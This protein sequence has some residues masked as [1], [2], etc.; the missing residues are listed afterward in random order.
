MERNT[1]ISPR[2]IFAG[3]AEDAVV[4]VNLSDENENSADGR[5]QSDVDGL[6]DECKNQSMRRRRP[7][8]PVTLSIP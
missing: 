6:R 4:G 2:H 3:Y 5:G 7:S 8:T 1:G